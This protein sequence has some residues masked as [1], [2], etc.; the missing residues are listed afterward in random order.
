MGRSDELPIASLME[1]ADK[2]LP[3]LHELPKT[4]EAI[5]DIVECEAVH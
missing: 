1:A 4:I 2:I 5:D 3:D